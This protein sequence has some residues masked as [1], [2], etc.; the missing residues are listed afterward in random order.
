MAQVS[1]MYCSIH[2]PILHFLKR[3]LL[4]DS[5]WNIKSQK[6]AIIDCGRLKFKEKTTRVKARFARE[7]LT[8]AR[9]VSKRDK[10]L[11]IDSVQ[12]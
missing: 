5:S 10:N 4:N 9:T 7:A 3:K 2:H 12:R 11:I 8:L 6:R 1:N